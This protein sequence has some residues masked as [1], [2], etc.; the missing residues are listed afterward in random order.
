MSPEDGYEQWLTDSLDGCLVLLA[1]SVA[2]RP[3]CEQRD[4]ERDSE[5][6]V[7]EGATLL[8]AGGEPDTLRL[9]QTEPLAL[10]MLGVFTLLSLHAKLDLPRAKASPKVMTAVRS[11]CAIADLRSA[12]EHAS[13]G[14][15]TTAT[16]HTAAALRQLNAN[17]RRRREARGGG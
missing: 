2:T 11:S 12:I 10:R 3:S 6:S 13:A 17:G 16:K 4:A 8:Q 15:E 9:T 7:V 5:A 1:R 14:D